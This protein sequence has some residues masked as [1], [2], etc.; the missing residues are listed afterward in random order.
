MA[1]QELLLSSP[2]HHQDAQV[3]C[4]PCVSAYLW[5]INVSVWVVQCMLGAGGRRRR[6]RGNPISRIRE[7]VGLTIW[8]HFSRAG[9][10]VNSKQSS[11]FS[12]NGKWLHSAT[13]VQTPADEVSA[14]C[15]SQIFR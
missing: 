7:R 9:L 15:L 13:I 8:F 4:Q 11:E 2:G 1:T 5:F 10:S 3:R 14:T 6:C 12:D